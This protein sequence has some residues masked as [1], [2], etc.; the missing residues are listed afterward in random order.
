MCSICIDQIARSIDITRSS[1]VII[2]E[3]N[4]FGGSSSAACK[5]IPLL[6]PLIPAMFMMNNGINMLQ[7]E[8]TA[9]IPMI[10]VI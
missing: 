9:L 5:A 8:I 1:L 7:P 3:G 4:R 2:D 10:R 6:I